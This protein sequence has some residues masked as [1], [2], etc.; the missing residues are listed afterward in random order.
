M[1]GI[2][3]TI[4]FPM[5]KEVWSNKAFHLVVP[6]TLQELS[7]AGIF[8]GET[9]ASIKITRGVWA[10]QELP[11]SREVEANQLAK[12]QR[13]AKSRVELWLL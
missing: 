8:A 5:I 3:S 2:R 6:V 13:F 11:G 7:V 12:G 4:E 9:T 10:Y 1:C